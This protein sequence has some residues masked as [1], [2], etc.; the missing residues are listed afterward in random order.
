MDLKSQ[1][2]ILFYDSDC[3]LCSRVVN[4]VLTNERENT[5][6]FASL[7]GEVFQELQKLH[8]IPEGVDSTILFENDQVYIE[9]AA[10]LNLCK[11]L[12]APFSLLAIFKIL[13]SFFSD[14]VYQWIARNRYN[15]YGT[16][17]FVPGA[18][19]RYLQKK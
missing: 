1:Q 5:L 11:Y 4:F 9:S 14:K 13:P 16:C 6:K 12:K 15:W 18:G 3:V 2:P 17:E 19:A 7:Q 10:A 8:S